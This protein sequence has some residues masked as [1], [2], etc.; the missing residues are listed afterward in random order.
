MPGRRLTARRPSPHRRAIRRRRTRTRFLLDARPPRIQF[1]GTHNRAIDLAEN[2]A[3][4][5]ALQKS[6]RVLVLRFLEYFAA[7]PAAEPS[8]R[9]AK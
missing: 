7:E 1:A 2:L 9:Q 6:G 8:S 5:Q 3:A 4:K